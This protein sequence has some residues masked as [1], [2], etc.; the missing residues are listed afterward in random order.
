M[1]GKGLIGKP[2]PWESVSLVETDL[3]QRY[4]K[5]IS[6]AMIMK[7]VEDG[8]IRSYPSF[9]INSTNFDPYRNFIDILSI[10]INGSA[11]DRIKQPIR[12]HIQLPN[13]ILLPANPKKMRGIPQK[14]SANPVHRDKQK[15]H[16]IRAHPSN[17]SIKNLLQQ[18]ARQQ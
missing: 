3:A 4:N 14:T 7:H 2:S 9:S 6:K 13:E 11:V 8:W 17:I 5:E 18:D 16:K 10:I 1:L 12:R 15:Q